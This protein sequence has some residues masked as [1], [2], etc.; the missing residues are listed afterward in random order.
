MPHYSFKNKQI[1]MADKINFE[2]TSYILGVLSIVTAFFIPSLGLVL[3]I[4]GLV[5]SRKQKTK[6]S[7]LSKK[8]N[9]IGIILS[10]VVFAIT[11]FLILKTGGALPAFLSQ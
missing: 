9:V 6:I 7:R 8:L 10:I 3:G 5:Q 4:I 11:F 1:K 2:L